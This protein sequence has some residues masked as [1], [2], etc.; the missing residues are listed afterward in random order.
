M[1]TE[2]AQIALAIFELCLLVGGFGLFL[3]LVLNPAARSR[4]LG[5]NVLPPK[6]WAAADFAL[7]A[8]SILL[9]AFA[10][11]AVIQLTLGHTIAGAADHQGIALFVYSVANY[12]GA[13][14][15]WR[16][17]FPSLRR[18]W[19]VEPE[20]ATPTPP[21]APMPWALA[22]RYAAATLAICLP[23]LSLA[24][25]G[26]TKVIEVLGL[27]AQPQDVVAIFVNTRSP[28]VVAGMLLVAC[29][30]APLY[31]ELLFRAGIYR[32]CR[33]RLG[34]TTGLLISGVCF[35][36]L[37]GNWLGFLP[38]ALLGMGLAIAYEATGSIRVPII[39]HGLFNLN[40]VIVL[41]SGLQEI[42]K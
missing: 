6:P 27:P 31:E 29:V 11:Q 39:A 3:W 5:T 30:L 33:Q 19:A 18:S 12:T 21:A 16:V 37:H 41:L 25:F 38:L 10:F 36:A 9:G 32:F 23:L 40:T 22:L 17:I 14:I 28:L 35:G 24:S 13:L 7:L 26:W 2:P 1:P 34:R 20:V 42:G 8:V 4:W 15:G